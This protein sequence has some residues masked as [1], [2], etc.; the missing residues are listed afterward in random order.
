ML[1]LLHMKL[2]EEFVLRE[3]LRVESLELLQLSAHL[4]EVFLDIMRDARKEKD[5]KG[6]EERKGPSLLFS[7]LLSLLFSS[8]ISLSR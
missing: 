2:F 1:L 4:A 5:E 6:K 7:P 3:L 8:L